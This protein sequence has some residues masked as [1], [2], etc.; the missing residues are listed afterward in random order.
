MRNVLLLSTMQPPL[1][2]MKEGRQPKP[3]IYKL[4]YFTKGGTDVIDQR[5]V[6]YTSKPKAPRWSVTALSY[7]LDTCRVNASTINAAM[8]AGRN[9]RSQDAFQLGLSM[10]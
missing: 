5:M 1:G 9:P 10:G 3:A 4:Y 2:S 6:Y 8:N 7:V